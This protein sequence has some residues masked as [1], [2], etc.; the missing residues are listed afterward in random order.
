MHRPIRHILIF[1]S[2]ALGL[3]NTGCRKEA[4][5]EDGANTPTGS[6][7]AASARSFG[8]ADPSAASP[9]AA[10][11]SLGT[12]L[13]SLNEEEQRA[14]DQAAN[15]RLAQQ[16]T[17]HG[18]ESFRPAPC[19]VLMESTSNI[20]SATMVGS[21]CN[22]SAVY[23]VKYDWYTLETFAYS[24]S[25]AFAFT[26]RST[27][28]PFTVYNATYALVDSSLATDI[29]DNDVGQCPKRRHFIVTVSNMTGVD[30][31]QATTWNTVSGTG[32]CQTNPVVLSHACSLD[33]PNS[34]YTNNDAR[35]T[36][37]GGSGLVNVFTDCSLCATAPP[38]LICPDSGT[39]MYRLLNTG[40]WTTQTL[41]AAGN[42][43]FVSPTGVYEYSCTLHYSF[44]NSLPRTGTFTIN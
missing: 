24:G 13:F 16:F 38:H 5:L 44:G 7:A 19:P 40:P 15:A 22:N 29:C 43:F 33:F 1:G 2:V 17:A 25:I 6:A 41:S 39:F 37:V 21:H 31:V 26:V 42:M 28:P 14:Q 20:R 35:V 10:S 4:L 11:L 18:G 32:S 9:D 27:V 3:L 30:Y 12:V 23:E 34:Y 36:V 8:S